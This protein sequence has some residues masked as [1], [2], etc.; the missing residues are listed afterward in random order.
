MR[1]RGLHSQNQAALVAEAGQ[2]VALNITAERLTHRLHAEA[3]AEKG[4]VALGAGFD[5]IEADAGMVRIGMSVGWSVIVAAE[6][7]VGA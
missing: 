5:H 7:A 2:R 4:Q 3:N 6:V 1:V